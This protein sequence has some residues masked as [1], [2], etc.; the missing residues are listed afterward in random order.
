VAYSNSGVETALRLVYSGYVDESES[1]DF[2]FN[3]NLMT[4]SPLAG[5][6]ALRNKRSQ[7]KA[8][9]VALIVNNNAYCGCASMYDGTSSS[10]FSVTLRNR[11]TGYFSFGHEIG[12]N[13]VSQAAIL[14]VMM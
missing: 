4:S 3:L 5:W 11:A 8:D 7:V 6:T 10:G 14:V 1:S 12:H 9:L 13:M 2:C